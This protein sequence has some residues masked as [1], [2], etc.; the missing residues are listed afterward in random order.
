L[1]T[2]ETFINKVNSSDSP[3]SGNACRNEIVFPGKFPVIKNF[4]G[5]AW[6][7]S[8]MFGDEGGGGEF[9]MYGALLPFYL[10]QWW[11]PSF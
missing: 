2:G 6:N 10:L 4:I 9:N 7:I 5:G 3:K 11:V 1:R 8:G